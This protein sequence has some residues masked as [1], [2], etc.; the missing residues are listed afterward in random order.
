MIEKLLENWLDSASERS[1][2]PVFVQM[3]AAEGY[4]I[5]H[6]TRHC[7][8]EF[9]KDVLAVA[10]DGHGCAFQLKGDPK[11]RMKIAEFRKDIQPQL[12][13]LLFQAPSYPGFPA[14][15]HRAYLVT[16][17][18]FEEEVQAAVRE[19]NAFPYP[20]KLDLWSRG[21]LFELCRKHGM[22]LWPGELADTRG[23]L[24]LY[25][26]DPCG[27]FPLKTLAGIL[28]TVLHLGAN[29][30]SL[31]GAELKRAATSASWITGI[32][33]GHYAEKENNQAVA[34]A[35]TLCCVMLIA[36]EEKH[37][38]IDA[39]CVQA[40]LNIAKSAVL[41]ALS[42][43]WAEVASRE[44]LVEGSPLTDPEVYGWRLSVLYGLLTS[45][46]IADAGSE[47]L[48]E[49]G[50]QGLHKWLK[51]RHPRFDIWG[52]STIAAFVPWLVWLRSTDATRRPDFEIA[53]A[54]NIVIGRNQKKG[55]SPL[56]SPYY[57]AEGIIRHRL[58][59]DGAP[60]GLNEETFAGSAY[61]AESLLHLLVRTNQKDK[62]RSVWPSFTKLGHRGLKFVLPWHYCLL[63]APDGIDDTKLYPPTYEWQ[64]LK[65]DVRTQGRSTAVP[66]ALADCPWLLSM[67][68]QV[69]P[70]RLNAAACGIFT[71]SVLPGWGS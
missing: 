43:L 39:G 52:E 45:L 32:S 5:L 14:G 34:L 56:P 63:Q 28:E 53:A 61:T 27:Q 44:H 16:N 58:G 12:V 33:V 59:L 64:Q 18:Q 9:G 31:N 49:E 42:A 13:Q 67:W 22:L 30:N 23:L 57:D 68:W 47:L 4:T 8:L 26:S 35:W 55:R 48:T 11:G 69:A 25:M 60:N 3:L 24:E 19:M 15:V 7:L 65:E 2:Q 70:H 62:C 54:A 38:G 21:H 6:S 29:A 41:D 50:R 20:A 40:S 37:A 71:E 66:K 51:A 36:A 46:A 17:G 1:Y 10:P